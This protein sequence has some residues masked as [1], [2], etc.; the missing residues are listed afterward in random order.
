MLTKFGKALRNIRFDQD[1][2]LKDMAYK[3]NV[4]P[5]FLSSIEVGKKN[6]PD[7][8]IEKIAQIYR[9]SLHQEQELIDLAK[10]STCKVQISLQ[11]KNNKDRELATSFA[12]KFEELND[13]EKEKI[14]NVLKGSGKVEPSN[15]GNS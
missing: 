1:E 11:N 8:M 5:S 14:L 10:E 7:S 6:V 13:L 2:L 15:H 3:L 12:R 9:L 4:T